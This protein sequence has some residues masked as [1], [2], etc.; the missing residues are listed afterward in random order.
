VGLSRDKTNI[1]YCYTQ[2]C[3]LAAN[4]AVAFAAKGFPV[5]ETDG[6]FEAWKESDLDIERE[7]VNR[8]KR[9]GERLLH[10]RH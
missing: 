5:M 1:L 3:H 6:G 10:R 8:L 9:A 2:N 7:P 4:A